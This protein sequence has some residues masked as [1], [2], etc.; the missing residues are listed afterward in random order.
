MSLQLITAHPVLT[1]EGGEM[2]VYEIED[3]GIYSQKHCVVA[4]S[5]EKAA[6]LWK[7]KYKSEPIGIKIYSE[8]V[9][10]QDKI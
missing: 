6:E 1:N 9:I 5:Y 3:I 4:E 7:Q 8:Y 2:K 10:I